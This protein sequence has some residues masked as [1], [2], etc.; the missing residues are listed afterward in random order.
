MIVKL[1]YIRGDRELTLNMLNHNIDSLKKKITYLK[2]KINKRLD[3]FNIDTI[4]VNYTEVMKLIDSKNNDSLLTITDQTQEKIY[5]VKAKAN[6]TIISGY[7]K[8]ID[9]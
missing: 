8:N 7:L 9:R 1:K 2:H 3:L 4:K 6:K 5:N